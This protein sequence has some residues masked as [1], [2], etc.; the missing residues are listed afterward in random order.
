MGNGFE[1]VPDG[2]FFKGER[3]RK[4]LREA[5]KIGQLCHKEKQV[6]LCTR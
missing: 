3:D 5:L 6:L 4:A 1:C 2:S